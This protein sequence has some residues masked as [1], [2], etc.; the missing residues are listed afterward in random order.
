VASNWRDLR[1]RV[2]SAGILGH[3]PKS[4]EPSSP[5]CPMPNLIGS[6]RN[7]KS[8]QSLF[9]DH[10]QGDGLMKIATIVTAMALALSSSYAFAAGAAAVRA[11]GGAA[12]APMGG[13]AAAPMGGSAG[14]PMGG[15]AAA[16][17]R[18]S[19]SPGVISPGAAP[20]TTTG[21]GTGTPGLNANGPCNGASPTSG[22]APSC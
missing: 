7:S 11:P 2:K 13:S 4:R 22:N 18:G 6:I 14:A 19:T 16:T 12:T 20:G 5:W 15:S 10:E 1:G 9:C 3:G 17:S 21:L 8:R